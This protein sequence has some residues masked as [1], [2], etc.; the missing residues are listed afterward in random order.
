MSVQVLSIRTRAAFRWSG[1][2]KCVAMALVVALLTFGATACGNIAL[3]TLG[4]GAPGP[5]TIAGQPS[6]TIAVPAGT[7]VAAAAQR[8]R[9]AITAGGGTVVTV[10]DHTAN[11]RAVGVQLP[12][13]TEVIGGPPPAG[14]P[15]LRIDQ[16]AA[17]N[18][19]QHY[20]IRQAADGTV[21]LT[22]NSADYIAAMSFVTQS[23]ASTA[24]RDSTAAVIGAVSPDSGG[25]I[26]S[27]L[28]GLTP[29]D[30]MITLGSRLAVPAAVDRL[31]RGAD[32]PPTR[33]L[34]IVDMALG[35]DVNG[36][37]I[38][39]TTLVLATLPDAE[40]ALVASTPAFAIDLPLRFVIWTDQQNRT[41][42]GY[43]D[44][45]RLALRHGVNPDDPT[46][47]RLAADA[48]RLARLGTGVP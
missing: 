13:I 16:R 33:S 47:A 25:I 21:T 20:L 30:Y 34:A 27:A 24:L 6:G 4:S 48:D 5:T 35:S 42:V 32:R 10:V 28:V 14:L 9:D 8:V 17:A 43:P 23:D 19:P 18:L 46:V 11:A 37:P 31:R 38:R 45:R 22:A 12:P 36:P 15:L 2:A 1:P 26:P 44:V 39:P 40:A 29:A 7:D 41:Q 3:G